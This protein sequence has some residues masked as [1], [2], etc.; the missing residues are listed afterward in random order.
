MV[1][2]VG[3]AIQATKVSLVSWVCAGG[4]ST[5]KGNF[6][7]T[8]PFHFSDRFWNESWVQ[9]ECFL[10]CK[11]LK[12]CKHHTFWVTEHDIRFSVHQRFADR[13]WEPKFRTVCNPAVRYHSL[14]HLLGLSLLHWSVNALN[15]VLKLLNRNVKVKMCYA[16]HFSL[17]FIL[18]QKCLIFS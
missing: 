12:G 11:C 17:F 10:R 16:R 18:Q 3:K 2:H 14:R 5:V 8:K 9:G 1:L 7:S 6:K 13:E 15:W 4:N